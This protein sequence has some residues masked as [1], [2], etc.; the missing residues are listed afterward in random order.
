MENFK[1]DRDIHLVC[2]KADS[3]PAGIEDA[4]RKL[5]FISN[6]GI[7]R[8]H[9]GVSYMYDDEILY[10]AA[11]EVLHDKEEIPAGCETYTLKKGD[12]ISIYLADFAKDT[13]QIGEAFKKLLA[14]PAIDE[15]GCCAE[16]YLP[17]GT[18]HNTAKDV[19][20]MVRLA[21]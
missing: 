21:G 11:A 2:V 15:N 14:N 4:H 9:F 5:A 1:L 3:F 17:E 20:C 6:P 18:D 10:M 19:R 16:C 12:Y 13:S 7:K 8:N